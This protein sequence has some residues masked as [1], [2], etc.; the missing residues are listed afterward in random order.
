MFQK[1]YL[2]GGDSVQCRPAEGLCGQGYGQVLWIR[3][4]WL[5]SLL[6]QLASPS[7]LVLVLVTNHF[8]A[9]DCLSIQ[10]R[11]K[12]KIYWTI[13]GLT[14]KAEGL[15]NSQAWGKHELRKPGGTQEMELEIS[16][17]LLG[18]RAGYRVAFTRKYWRGLLATVCSLPL[19]TF[20]TKE[21]RTL[22]LARLIKFWEKNLWPTLGP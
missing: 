9:S 18:G 1:G 10:S 21:K 5:C 12:N 6:S 11:L 22:S 17:F 8:L 14:A 15:Q 3:E 7:L 16:L 20:S 19:P 4:A 13:T 2:Y